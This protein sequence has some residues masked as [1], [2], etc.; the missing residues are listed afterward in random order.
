MGDEHDPLQLMDPDQEIQL[1]ACRLV[2]V[3]LR[4]AWHQPGR[5]ARNGPAVVARDQEPLVAEF[6]KG[7]S[8]AAVATIKRQGADA[9]RV[10]ALVA[11][12]DA[13]GQQGTKVHAG[14]GE[15]RGIIRRSHRAHPFG[16]AGTSPFGSGAGWL[17][18][19]RSLRGSGVSLAMYSG[20][21]TPPMSFM[22]CI[23]GGMVRARPCRK[24]A[25]LVVPLELPPF[26]QTITLSNFIL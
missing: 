23:I 7:F 11:G 9:L 19:L 3:A 18:V 15:T 25:V 22:I 8:P 6:V 17:A 24:W 1:R 21:S 26:S 12:V 2:E 20:K 10:P 4:L 13:H 14:P 5:A 16:G